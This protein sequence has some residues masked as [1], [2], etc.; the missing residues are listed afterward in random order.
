MI[1]P[2]KQYSI[3]PI[4]W[5]W[6]PWLTFLGFG[7]FHAVAPDMYYELLDKGEFGGI[8]ILQAI[9]L[10]VG[11]VF[12][13]FV[14][15]DAWKTG[16]R[17]LTGWVGIATLGCLY[18]F[19]EE[20]SYGQHFIGWETSEF[21]Q[22]VNDQG[23]TNL[24]NTSSWLDQK[25]RLVLEIGVIVGGMI[26]PVLEKY[27]P[28]WLPKKFALIYPAGALFW[29]AFLGELS[30]ILAE[31]NHAKDYGDMIMGRVSEVQELAYYYFVLLYLVMLRRKLPETG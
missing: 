10:L 17:Y 4:W 5:F 14:L 23:E 22:R 27:K 1:I 28:E 6:A 18:V 26:I 29:T 11:F 30:H 3:S 19:L 16:N 20:I 8:E 13:L 9:V 2:G 31:L 21:W 15:R 12:S 25:P 24:H 7:V